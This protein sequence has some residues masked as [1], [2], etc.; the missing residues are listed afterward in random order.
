MWP[1]RIPNWTPCMEK[2]RDRNEF[3]TKEALLFIYLKVYPHRVSPSNIAWLNDALRHTEIFELKK[4]DIIL[5]GG[6][7]RWKNIV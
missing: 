3:L 2:Q 6:L 5:V 1:S 4:Q 7:N